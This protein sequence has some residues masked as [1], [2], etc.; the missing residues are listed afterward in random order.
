MIIRALLSAAVVIAVAMN[1]AAEIN[2]TGRN[3]FAPLYVLPE[4]ASLS[5]PASAVPVQ[6]ADKTQAQS[7]AQGGDNLRQRTRPF[8]PEMYRP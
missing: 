3:L 6:P 1:I 2:A 5:V 7:A 4:P 8:S